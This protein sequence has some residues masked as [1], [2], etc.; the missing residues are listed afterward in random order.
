LALDQVYALTG[1]SAQ[2]IAGQAAEVI[3]RWAQIAGALILLAISVKPAYRAIRSRI[4]I[5]KTRVETTV[6]GCSSES[7]QVEDGSIR[8][9]PVLAPAP[10]HP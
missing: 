9:A 6:C 8:E 7:C 4:P 2:A 5:G 10:K 3:P 1:I